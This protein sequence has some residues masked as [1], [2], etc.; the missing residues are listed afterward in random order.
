M[1]FEAGE[2]I[3]KTGEEDKED[4]SCDIICEV[5]KNKCEKQ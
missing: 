1:A 4:N 5:L 2:H 3:V